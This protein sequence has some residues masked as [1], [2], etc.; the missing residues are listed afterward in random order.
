VSHRV[1]LA[2]ESIAGS[3]SGKRAEGVVSRHL[4]LVDPSTERVGLD[5]CDWLA[6]VEGVM[7]ELAQGR[8]GDVLG[9]IAGEHLRT[10][11]K[12]LRARLALAAAETFGRPRGSVVGWAAACELL[13]NATL[14]HD[15]LQDGDETRRGHATLWSR[16]GAAQAINA[17]DL[18]LMLPFLALER[19]D[20]PAETRWLLSRTLAECAA[21]VARGQA[22]EF[23]ADAAETTEWSRYRATAAGKTGA[24]FQLPVEGA[25]LLAGH[26]EER[27]RSIG[28]EF[29]RL[30]VLFQLQDDVLD[31]YGDKGRAVAGSDLREGRVTALV[32]EYLE[33]VP[34]DRAWL[35]ALLA[36]P[37]AATPEAEVAEAI[38]RFRERGALAAVLERMAD[39]AMAVLESPVLA[40]EPRLRALAGELVRVVLAPIAHLFNGPARPGYRIDV[41]PLEDMA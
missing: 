33:R 24:L 40:A 11:G 21:R 15:D 38:R 2:V 14:V 28:E 35:A 30:G 17:G 4:H 41:I 39:E 16:H 18:M 10:G 34:G 8:S 36:L 5:P 22:A 9:R 20:A 7:L 26:T 13:H 31:L 19:V 3:P 37:R 1:P 6:Q 32:V 25:A 27:T 12:R 23:A 29:Q